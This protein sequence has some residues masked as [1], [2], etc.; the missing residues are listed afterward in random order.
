LGD[1]Y[2]NFGTFGG[3]IFMLVFGWMFNVVL[4]GF[5]KFSRYYPI[6]LL[7]TPLVF[8]FPIRPDTALQTSMG[9]LVKSSFLLYIIFMF[10]KKDLE[11]EKASPSPPGKKFFNGQPLPGVVGIS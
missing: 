10:W 2:I 5:Y 7:F 8:Y 4:N 1:A 9:H 11:K 3:S 6:A